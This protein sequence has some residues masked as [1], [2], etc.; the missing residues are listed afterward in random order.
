MA[1]LCPITVLSNKYFRD[2]T[3]GIK[4]I[5]YVCQERIKTIDQTFR[6]NVGSVVVTF[7]PELTDEIT[8]KYVN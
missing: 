1:V 3:N 5:V 4:T 2:I 8:T 6:S 7:L